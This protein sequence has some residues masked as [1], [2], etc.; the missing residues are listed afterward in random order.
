MCRKSFEVTSNPGLLAFQEHLDIVLSH[1][2]HVHDLGE[3]SQ[4]YRAMDAQP[5]EPAFLAHQI[6]EI[7]MIL[8]S[9]QSMAPAVVLEYIRRAEAF[10]KAKQP[11]W[12]FAAELGISHHA[13][14]LLLEVMDEED[15]GI[16]AAKMLNA[17][18]QAAAMEIYN[19]YADQQLENADIDFGGKI[20]KTLDAWMQD[21]HW[22]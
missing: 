3:L 6:L 17:L 9:A 18:H 7:N 15:V 16:V 19:R 5:L 12:D 11:D 14:S 22:D 13:A 10:I 4:L 21:S 1:E 2:F 20:Q 8:R